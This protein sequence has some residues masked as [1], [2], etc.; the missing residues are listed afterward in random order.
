MNDLSSE[1]LGNWRRVL[2]SLL[3]PFA[4]LLSDD[5]IKDF[6]ARAQV[7]IE[8][9]PKFKQWDINRDIYGQGLCA[10]CGRHAD[11]YPGGKRLRTHADAQ[12]QP[13]RH[14]KAVKPVGILPTK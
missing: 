10:K 11:Y 4:L 2:T 9:G 8:R 13:C 1:Q 5:E 14:R 6:C 3:G 7:N 12:G